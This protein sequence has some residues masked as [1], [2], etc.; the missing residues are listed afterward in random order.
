[1]SMALHDK[2]TKHWA[3]ANR[4]SAFKAAKDGFLTLWQQE[5]NFRLHLLITCFVI[6]LA[7]YFK[8]TPIEWCVI[9]LLIGL[10]LTLEMINSAIENVVDLIVG[11]Q[12]H[13]L[14]KRSKDIAAAAVTLS[15]LIAIVIGMIIFIPHIL[16]IGQN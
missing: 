10:V 16:S 12:W 4:L 1:M 9:L 7:I 5:F 11:T 13:T 15:A 14:A 6:I 8:L 3:N 2:P